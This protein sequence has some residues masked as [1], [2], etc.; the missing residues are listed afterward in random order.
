MA[1]D[2]FA[3]TKKKDDLDMNHDFFAQLGG[4]RGKQF[5]KDV[6]ITT[7]KFKDVDKFLES[8]PEVQRGMNKNRAKD[9]KKYI[10]T[11]L[12]SNEELD[13]RFFNSV[14]A[15]CRGTMI[16][17]EDKRTVLIDTQSKLSINDG[18]HRIAG[19]KEAMSEMKERIE[20]TTDLNDRRELE[21][22]LEILS[23]MVIPVTVF[24]GISEEQESQLFHDL[25]NLPRRPSRNANI[26]LSQTDLFARM[27]KDIS[28]ENKYFQ[29]YGVEMDKQFISGKNENVF[30]LSTIYNSIKHL[31]NANLILDKSFLKRRN[32]DRVKSEVNR[33]FERILEQLPSDM[34]VKGKY[35]ID[36]SYTLAGI[37]RFVA[38][39]NE[40]LLFADKE[41]IYKV[42]KDT[43]W[44]Y[45]NTDWLKY[46]GIRGKGDN[47]IFSATSSGVKGIFNSLV[48]K[49]VEF[50]EKKEKSYLKN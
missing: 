2:K 9:I 43:N 49:A 40:N 11:A 37:C 50:N 47:I 36:K 29:H 27:A 44:S 12:F 23:E 31:L 25:N 3:V 26:R 19:I 10:L 48:D 21:N 33:Q 4:I 20:R 38:Y 18:Q 14:T 24:N 17:D 30:L 35:I 28:N 39:A 32:Y 22:K 41:D 7:V 6:Y 45:K 15:T 8:F 1:F 5:G 46:G 16:Y 34:D 42:I 13:Y